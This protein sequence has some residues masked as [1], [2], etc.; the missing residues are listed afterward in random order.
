MTRTTPYICFAC[1]F[2][3]IYL[4]GSTV[5]AAE[6]RQ[7]GNIYHC[8]KLT[9]EQFRSLPDSAVIECKGKRLTKGQRNAEANA[10]FEQ[11]KKQLNKKS[12]SKFETANAKFIKTENDRIKA[13]NAKALAAFNQK[14]MSDQ[15]LKTRSKK[16][17]PAQK[18]QYLAIQKEARDLHAKAQTAKTP[19][20]RR[21]IDQRAAE[22]ATQLKQTGH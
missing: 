7:T 10:R 8:E 14:K 16:M 17:S 22:L 6:V 2:A 1:L 5:L 15:N 20:E 13:D 4:S 18:T 9:K 3:G 21:Q 11:R 12:T 19:A